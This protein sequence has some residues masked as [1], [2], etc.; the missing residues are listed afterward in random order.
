MAKVTKKRGSSGKS[1]CSA[2]GVKDLRV[3]KNQNAQ[4][5]RLIKKIKKSCNDLVMLK[6]STRF[7]LVVDTPGNVNNLHMTGSGRW[8]TWAM[9]KA[10][11]LKEMG[12]DEAKRL[13]EL[14]VGKAASQQQKGSRSSPASSSISLDERV[15][16]TY[17]DPKT[18]GLSTHRMC[19]LTSALS[20]AV[21][22]PSWRTNLPES[23]ESFKGKGIDLGEKVHGTAAIKCDVWALL[24]TEGWKNV[25]DIPGF[26]TTEDSL[27]QSSNKRFVTF[28]RL[29]AMTPSEAKN[30]LY[31]TAQW[32]LTGL[33]LMSVRAGDTTI[34]SPSPGTTKGIMVQN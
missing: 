26:P 9:N 3:W 31:P 6:C 19:K 24:S 29:V 2:K 27:N 25:R 20:R 16:T 1:G 17:C 32:A 4:R 22:H 8:V 21:R 34:F 28:D 7:L 18:S 30:N 23:L 13:G 33:I 12:K 10:S 11:K 15:R 14:A 5:D